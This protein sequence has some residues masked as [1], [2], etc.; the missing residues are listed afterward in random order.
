MRWMPG[1]GIRAEIS[2]VA[3]TIYGR[4]TSS[5]VQLV[6]WLVG[7]LGLDQERLDRG[8]VYGGLDTPEFLAVNPNGRVPVLRSMEPT[9]FAMNSR[10]SSS[11]MRYW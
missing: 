11:S 5:N 10:S 8:H 3:L 9:A 6:M 7:E 1:G 4:A 2:G